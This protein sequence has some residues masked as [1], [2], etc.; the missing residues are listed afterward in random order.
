MICLG[1]SETI[2]QRSSKIKTRK[3]KIKTDL[4][5]TYA[6]NDAIV[7]GIDKVCDDTKMIYLLT[8]KDENGNR[9]TLCESQVDKVLE[10][11]EKAEELDG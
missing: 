7:P 2:C 11:I 8:V 1:A 4:Q 10:A 5:V 3:I 6:I 9:L